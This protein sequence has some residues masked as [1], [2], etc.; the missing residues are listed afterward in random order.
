MS[1]RVCECE[2][3]CN[4]VEE[5]YEELLA[6]YVPLIR[7][8]AL[9]VGPTYI[10]SAP[11]NG[12]MDHEDLV[13]EG[14]MATVKAFQSYNQECGVPLRAYV[15]LCAKRAMYY[16]LRAQGGVVHTP[17][18]AV[19]QRKA[20]QQKLAKGQ[21]LTDRVK[22]THECVE[23]GLNVRAVYYR[24]AL[25]EPTYDDDSFDIVESHDDLEALGWAFEML[26]EEQRDLL[27]RFYGV[28]G[29]KAELQ[30]DVARSKGTSR[31]S[32]ERLRN[33]AFRSLEHHISKWQR[34]QLR[35]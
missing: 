19:R 31:W 30:R 12:G 5:R 22:K 25:G 34:E 2:V 4:C 16:A 3:A 13:Q 32:M 11:G 23:K 29:G 21:T 6:S 24:P 33:K 17:I 20:E 9:Q 14:L 1:S 18:A 35:V 26:E 10:L 28:F 7:S 8:I 15:S 27:R